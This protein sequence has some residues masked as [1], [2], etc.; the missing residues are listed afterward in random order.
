MTEPDFTTILED[1]A[2]R[3]KDALEMGGKDKVARQHE[4]GRLTARER[5]EYFVD[6]DSF[7]E[8]GMLNQSE[9][10]GDE[11]KSPADGLIGGVARVNGRPVVIEATDKTV[12][13]GAEGSVHVRKVN[14]IHTYAAK[15][16][17]PLICLA[18][19]GGLRI[20]DALGSD[21]ISQNL[22]PLSLLN[23]GRK[24]PFITGIMGDSY[25]MPTWCG[26]SSDFTVQV[27][28]VCMAV[29]GPRILEIATYEKIS[30]EE[31][32]GW[33]MHA[34][35]TGQV[36][37]FAQNDKNCIKLMK[38][39]LSY[40]PLNQSEEPPFKQTGDDPYRRIDEALKIV[41]TRLRR[42][43]NMRHLIKVIVDN[44]IYMELKADFGKAL[45]T[46]LARMNGRVVGI[47]AN[48]PMVSAGAMGPNEADKATDFIC[49][50]DSFN[51]PLIFLHDVPGFLVG[52]KAEKMKMPTKIMVWNQA[53]V[54]A[55]VPVISIIIRKSTGAAYANMSGPGM[56]N[57]FIVAWPTADINFTGPE[58]GV[59][60]VY[61]AELAKAENAD[62]KR[63]E[64]LKQ[65]AFDSSPYKAAAKNLIDDI[66]DPRDTRKFICQTL[67]FACHKNG[68]IGEHKLADWP[69]GF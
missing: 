6:S 68:S 22:F 54:R 45:L 52:S 47:I 27:K 55:S 21:G 37:A 60:V 51:I 56:G 30:P 7:L 46:C 49:L 66:I 25:G 10:Q 2:N 43:Y 36:D 69:T 59:N 17:F 34:K 63:A 31:L 64:L 29:A 23:H 50:C 67:E 4:L 15:R 33:E 53:L 41:P 42:L 57:D 16:S 35:Y 39:F 58:V 8:M 18:E 32:G 11:F 48:Q 1:L 24:T 28:G 44:G 13:A 61:G 65:W 20:P 38:E 12:F 19:G 3:R 5:I 26:V 62:A 14:K 9:F 40:M